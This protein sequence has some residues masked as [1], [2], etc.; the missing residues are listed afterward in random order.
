[1]VFRFPYVYICVARIIWV[2]WLWPH[3][4]NSFTLRS[5]RSRRISGHTH[6]EWRDGDAMQLSFTKKYEAL[7]CYAFYSIEFLVFWSFTF[8]RKIDTNTHTVKYW[9]L[10]LWERVNGWMQIL[11]SYFFCYPFSKCVLLCIA[12][13]CTH[14]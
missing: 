8:D 4:A 9:K 7:V 2:S 6:Q 3:E 1:M 14:Q 5:N 10:W 11:H 12:W 13:M